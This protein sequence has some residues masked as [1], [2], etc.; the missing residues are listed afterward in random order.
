MSAATATAKEEG[1]NEHHQE[2][3]KQ[4]LGDTRGGARDTTE[5]Q[6]GSDNGN[7][8]EC[9]CPAQHGDSPYASIKGAAFPGASKATGVL[10]RTPNAPGD[11]FHPQAGPVTWSV[12]DV[13]LRCF[14]TEFHVHSVILKLYSAFFAKFLDSPDKA[15]PQTVPVGR[16]KY[17][18]VSKV[19]DDGSWG[20]E[21]VKPGEVRT[22]T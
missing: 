4:N 21:A 15:H 17:E 7:D 22:H 19:D 9:D 2:H 18:W 11:A 20:F 6:Y 3:D 10:P 13:R 8:Q 12:V 5:A 1:S 16:F 14:D